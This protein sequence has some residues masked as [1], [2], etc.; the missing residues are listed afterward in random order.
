MFKKGQLVRSSLG[1]FYIVE[2]QNP[3]FVIVRSIA[4]GYCDTII[5][6]LLSR[7]G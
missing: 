7:Q 5:P 1:N 6:P 4:H 3:L 2:G